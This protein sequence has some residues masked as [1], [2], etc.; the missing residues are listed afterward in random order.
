MP[1]PALPAPAAP[2]PLD[3]PSPSAAITK[4][5]V[6]DT[7]GVTFT[8]PEL[9][10]VRGFPGRSVGKVPMVLQNCT[11]FPAHA[12][13]EGTGGPPQEVD[14]A[15]H[16]QRTVEVALQGREGPHRVQVRAGYAVLQQRN[17]LAMREIEVVDAD[18]ARALRVCRACRG[19]FG[20]QGIA[21][22]EGCVCRTRDAGKSCHDAD[23]CEG[24]CIAEAPEVITRSPVPLGRPI[25]TCSENVGDLGCV[26]LVPHGASSEPPRPLPLPLHRVCRD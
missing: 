10:T 13:I 5:A 16:E 22:V 23:E 25:G 15:P 9:A 18:R 8:L 7:E 6:C 26:A 24:D 14:L 11:A 3:P 4:A 12:K 19:T 17:L 1:L 21:Q 20:P 2:L